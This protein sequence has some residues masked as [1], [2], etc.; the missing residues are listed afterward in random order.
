MW[1]ICHVSHQPSDAITHEHNL[2]R[3]VLLAGNYI[4]TVAVPGV[5]NPAMFPSSL[6]ID[7]SPPRAVKE[8]YSFRADALPGAQ[9]TVS[10]HQRQRVM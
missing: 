6:S 10:K 1:G 3:S 5:S 8:F 9:R 7:L 2:L 4:K